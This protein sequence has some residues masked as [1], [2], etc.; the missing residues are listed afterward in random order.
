MPASKRA[1]GETAATAAGER[2][3]PASRLNFLNWY[4]PRCMGAERGCLSSASQAGV[5]NSDHTTKPEL[6]LSANEFL[7]QVRLLLAL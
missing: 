7:M 4:M 5:G 2:A 6:R 3:V 1:G